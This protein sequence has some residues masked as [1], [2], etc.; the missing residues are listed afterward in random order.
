MFEMEGKYTF[1]QNKHILFSW[2][3]YFFIAWSLMSFH[4]F[5]NTSPDLF[6]SIVFKQIQKELTYMFSNTSTNRKML[7]NS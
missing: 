4:F 1:Q 3:K 6:K 2:C 5:R 7:Y